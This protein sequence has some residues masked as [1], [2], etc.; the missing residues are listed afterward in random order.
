MLRIAIQT[1]GRL[2][3][4]SVGLL[5]DSGISFREDKRKFLLKSADFPIEALY[6][7]DDDIPEAVSDGTADIGI[8]GYNEVC[9]RDK[10][11]DILMRLSFGKCRLSLAI[12]DSETC[13]SLQYFNGKKIA[14]S[15]PVILGKFLK[16]NNIKAEIRTIAGSV[17]IAPAAGLSDV[18]FDIVSS[19]ATLVS[20]GLKEVVK[21]LESEAVLICRKDISEKKRK[22]IDELRFR[23][24]SVIQARGA[25]YLL[26]NLPQQSVDEAVKILPALRSPTILPLAATGWCSMHSVVR[27]SELWDKIGQL[28]QIGAEGIVVM[29]VEKIVL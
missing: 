10:D 8:V 25:K 2:N 21:V 6:L 13:A 12:P 27:E 24:E 15:Y 29:D 28:K 4:D 20:N 19:G 5:K 14:T 17:E 9:E 1:K 7:R 11:V 3:E 23:F 16:E 18:I 22:L 26:M